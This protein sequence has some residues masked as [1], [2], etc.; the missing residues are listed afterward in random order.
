MIRRVATHFGWHV[1]AL[2]AQ[3]GAAEPSV[4]LRFEVDSDNPLA[5]TL[6][7]DAP[8]SSDWPELAAA[9]LA[10]AAQPWF[11]LWQIGRAHV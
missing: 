8:A 6:I 3:L 5:V 10:R 11:G 9:E 1:W 4:G 2:A 7:A